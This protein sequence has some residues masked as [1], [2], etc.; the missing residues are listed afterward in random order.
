M[1][2]NV[3][4][5]IALMYVSDYGYA[6]SNCETK[7]LYASSTTDL[8]ACND[9]NWLYNIKETEWLLPQ[10]SS[11]SYYAFGVYSDGFVS[12]GGVYS[13][14]FAVRP[15]VYLTSAVQITGGD[16][17]ESSPYTLGV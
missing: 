16:G 7:K 6:S 4:L 17:T 15:V 1:K 5:K 3:K 12:N 2:E 8:R 10:Y 9:T 11:S 13:Y 14:Q